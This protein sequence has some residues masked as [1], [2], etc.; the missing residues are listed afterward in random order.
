MKR[1]FSP[2]LS[3]IGSVLETTGYGEKK[4]NQREREKPFIHFS[5]SLT[6]PTIP[7]KIHLGA[8]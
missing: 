5:Q 4:Q 1:L 8:F 7:H 2:G 3:L 6:N